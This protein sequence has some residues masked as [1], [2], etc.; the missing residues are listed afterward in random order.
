MIIQALVTIG[1]VIAAIIL[2]VFLLYVVFFLIILKKGKKLVKWI[3]KPI[4][5]ERNRN[6]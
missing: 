6:E 5:D 4:T 3:F 2:L 1:I